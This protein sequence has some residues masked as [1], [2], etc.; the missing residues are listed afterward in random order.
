M[1]FLCSQ[2][3]INPC[4]YLDG[5]VWQVQGR[6]AAVDIVDGCLEQTIVKY[7]GPE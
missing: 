3:P 5:A 6:S 4:W 2:A 7:A 1:K